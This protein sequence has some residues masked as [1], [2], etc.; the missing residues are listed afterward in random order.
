MPTVLDQ[1][2]PGARVAILRLRSLGDCVLTTSAI[3]VLK[4]YRD[5][6]AIAVV[7][8]PRFRAVFT[9]NPDIELL[10]EPEIR[11]VRAFRPELCLNFHGGARSA[12]LTFLSGARLRAGFEHYRFSFLYNV[13]IPRAQ[14]ILKEERIVHTVEHLSSAM[15]Y[16]GVPDREIPRAGLFPVVPPPPVDKPF[17]VFHPLASQPAKTW[18]AG[19]FVEVARS[20][21]RE[22]H[23]VFVGAAG[24]DLTPFSEFTCLRGNSLEQVKSLLANAALFVGNDSGPAH[25]AAAFGVPVVVLFGPSDSNV[26]YPWRT[27]SR[28]LR[29]REGIDCISV[30]RVVQ[31]LQELRVTV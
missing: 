9:G 28:V 15:F 12:Q 5:D 22:L 29:S 21:Q 14:Q 27:P 16:L 18:P 1:L 17:C 25:M 8:E 26:W 23:P 6:L 20:I 13:R 4:R 10:L 19:S 11:L 24:D 7:V 31:S 3:R 2:A 30:E